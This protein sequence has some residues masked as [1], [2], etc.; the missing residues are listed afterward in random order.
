MLSYY[1]GIG[2]AVP[3]LSLTTQLHVLFPLLLVNHL[4]G[5]DQVPMWLHKGYQLGYGN[6]LLVYET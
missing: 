1:V 4:M 5:C 2:L 6:D 3:Q